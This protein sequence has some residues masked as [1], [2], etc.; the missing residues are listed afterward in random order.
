MTYYLI[1]F[2][3]F[4][5]AKRYI[6]K[7][8]Q[9]I[10]KKFHIKSS[11]IPHIT[12]VGPFMLSHK[13]FPLNLFLRDATEEKLLEEFT[14]IMKE[15]SS[16]ITF[17]LRNFNSFPN[18]NVVYVDIEPSENLKQ[19][20]FMLYKRLEKFCRL[21]KYD[22]L[23][24]EDFKFH[25]TIAMKIPSF[26]FDRICEY[27]KNNKPKEI[28]Q[29]LLRVTLIKNQRIMCE[30]DLIQKKLLSRREAKSR[31]GFKRTIEMLKNSIGK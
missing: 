6:K 13:P 30:Y 26:K 7:I 21:K 8:S 28:N 17:K 2:R 27:L 20:R 25:A 4:G 31:L 5:Y 24:K 15:I 29:Y 23:S 19:L 11:K 14:K 9:K 1:E 16:F 22:K 10:S 18:T 3:F 12:L